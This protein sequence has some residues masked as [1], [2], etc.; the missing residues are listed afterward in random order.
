MGG[1]GTAIFRSETI[2]MAAIGV[3]KVTMTGVSII[4]G[5]VTTYDPYTPETS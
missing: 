1:I 4:A 5:A 3:E 2:E